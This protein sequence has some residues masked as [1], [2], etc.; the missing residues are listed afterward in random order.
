[1][2]NLDELK[3]YAKKQAL[4]DQLD[5]EAIEL[6]EKIINIEPNF[7]DGYDRLIMIYFKK[8][9]YEKVKNLCGITLSLDPKNKIAKNRLTDIEEIE[10]LERERCIAEEKDR[11]REEDLRRERCIAEEKDREREEDLRHRL[12]DKDFKFVKLV[13]D[14]LKDPLPVLTELPYCSPNHN[15]LILVKMWMDKQLPNKFNDKRRLLNAR[16]A[17]V[18]MANYYR[19]QGKPVIDISIT[20]I[21]PDNNGDWQYYDLLVDKSQRID[22]KNSTWYESK[23]KRY[24]KHC[25]P[26][27]KMDRDLNQVEIVGVLSNWQPTEENRPMFLGTLTKKYHDLLIS[28][29]SGK[30]L[31]INFQEKIN[32]PKMFLPP[33][34]YNYPKEMYQ[35]RDNA[36]IALESMICPNWEICLKENINL[37]PAYIAAGIPINCYP[38]I[39]LTTIQVEFIEFLQ[40]KISQVGLLSIGVVFLSILEHFLMILSTTHTDSFSCDE[41]RK[42]VFPKREGDTSRP[43]FLYDPLS[44]IERLLEC[45]Q[46][47][48][49]R[50]ISSNVKEFK[51]FELPGPDILCGKRNISEQVW[52]TLL[53]YC[54]NGKCRKFPLLFGVQKNCTC[55]HLKCE[56][57]YCKSDC[58]H[59]SNGFL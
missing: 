45:L 12:D 40:S 33:W 8:K 21:D 19:S 25:I 41:Y 36:L 20:Q 32:S 51:M 55:G 31:N 48:W 11:E 7:V 28:K 16:L 35:L 56:C 58:P 10:K 59:S 54:G 1:M 27:F 38:K 49:D 39:P 47:L 44:T 34:I 29:F 50:R 6:N 18:A 5:D 30:L 13:T 43:L 37:I 15:D 26:N 9:D 22:V 3:A 24:H 14:A 53:A 57:G 23:T 46:L 17:E 2:I 4:S 42:I 52:T